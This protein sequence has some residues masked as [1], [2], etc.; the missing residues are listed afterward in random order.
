MISKALTRTKA[1]TAVWPTVA[2]GRR[3]LLLGLV[4]TFSLAFRFYEYYHFREMNTDKAR[5]LQGAYELLRG[6]GLSFESYDL[7][8]FQPAYVP[9][10]EWPPGYS[11]LIAA[12]SFSTGVDVYTASFI[13]DGLCLAGL[14]ACMAWLMSLLDFTLLQRCLLFLFLGLSKTPLNLISSSDL[15]GTV[16]FL[17]ACTVAVWHVGLPPQRRRPALFYAAEATCLL[18]MVFLKYSL[19]PAC[20]AVGASLMAYSFFS[21]EKF[22]K[23]GL[24]L[25]GVLLLFIVALFIH[26]QWRSGHLTDMHNRYETGKAGLHLDN[27]AMFNPFLVSGLVHIEL[28]YQRFHID[29][30]RAIGLVL[31]A[32]LSAGVL[33]VI[34]ER[35]KARRADYFDHLVYVTLFSVVGFLVLLSVYYP[36]DDH[37]TSHQWTYVKNFRYFAPAVFLLLLFLVRMLR[38][39]A[40]TLSWQNAMVHFTAACLL[41]GIGLAG[42][43]IITNNR[44]ASYANLDGKFL[45]IKQVTDSLRHDQTYFVSLTRKHGDD[46]GGRLTDT[47]ATSVVATAGTK[48][49]VSGENYFPENQY[50]V[51]FSDSALLPRGKR[52]IVFLDENTKMLDS[53]NRNNRHWLGQTAY[54]ERYLVI[55]N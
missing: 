18:L 32:V 53:I 28:F 24:V 7:R 44:A 10:V 30:V 25:F 20:F 13:L 26:N 17:A 12:I 16:V 40:R 51:L 6:N 43:Y 41:F 46:P 27:L 34:A 14:W 11:L 22:Y 45:R 35:I 9:I 37:P 52:V 1:L 54:G 8:T 47:K 55:N 36:K 49:V 19:L 42:Y 29:T 48:V 5:Q 33:L 50:S 38:Y 2:S 23:T 15:L 31:T 3:A 4:F 21:K 39:P